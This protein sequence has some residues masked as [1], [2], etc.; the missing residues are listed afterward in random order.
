MEIS[1]VTDIVSLCCSFYALD[2]TEPL[3]R[4][5][6]VGTQLCVRVEEECDQRAQRWTVIAEINLLFVLLGPFT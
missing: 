4:T 5:E 6:P 3:G 1:V 2:T